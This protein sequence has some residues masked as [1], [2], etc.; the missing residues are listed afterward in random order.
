MGIIDS[1]YCNDA[2]TAPW[3][4]SRPNIFMLHCGTGNIEGG[5]EGVINKM[6]KGIKIKDKV[7]IKVNPAQG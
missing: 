5:G 4:S 6:E 3:D 1:S 7:T 2:W